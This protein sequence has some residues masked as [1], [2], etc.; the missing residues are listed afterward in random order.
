ML[1]GPDAVEEA[2]RIVAEIAAR[3]PGGLGTAEAPL[4]IATADLLAEARE[5]LMARA[6]GGT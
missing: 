2:D 3:L 5:L 4:D 1:A 6:A